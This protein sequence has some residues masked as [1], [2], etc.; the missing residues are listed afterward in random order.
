MSRP[1]MMNFTSRI[2]IARHGFQS[3]TRHLAG[4]YERYREV[5]ARH[6][7][8]ISATRVRNVVEHFDVEQAAEVSAW[9]KILERRRGRCC[10]RRGGGLRRWRGRRREEEGGVLVAPAQG[11]HSQLRESRRGE[12]E[13][14]RRCSRN[15]RMM[16]KLVASTQE[17][18][19]SSRRRSHRSASASVSGDTRA[20][21]H[22]WGG[23]QGVQEAHGDSAGRPGGAGTSRSRRGSRWW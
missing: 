20:D 18:S 9:R 11:L 21:L 8:D 13:G 2:D 6:G 3:V 10:A 1:P 16:A 7:I 19:L 5:C 17:N 15:S 12:V 22:A 14:E 23:G 4:E